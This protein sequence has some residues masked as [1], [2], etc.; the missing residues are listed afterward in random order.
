MT[1]RTKQ[2][3]KDCLFF[4]TITCCDWLP[5]FKLTDFYNEI[6]KWFDLLV[7]KD[8]IIHGYVIMPNH[9]H[10]LIYIPEAGKNL[11]TLI[12][13]GKRF[14][15]YEIVKRLKNKGYFEILEKLSSKVTEFERK[16]GQL[17]K[18]F[19]S[20]FDA[21]PCYSEEF[22]IQKLDYIHHN[23]VNG[24]WSVVDDFTE[25]PHSSA[26]FYELDEEGIYK[27]IHFKEFTG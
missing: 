10:L 2:D 5:L 24:K 6:Y 22:I 9:L 11:N 8:C 27:V 7:K 14:M 26:K 20:S 13:N 18:A 15:A 21:K 19:Q 3:E 23:S 1:T 17:H 12:S 16:K 4:C 25:Y